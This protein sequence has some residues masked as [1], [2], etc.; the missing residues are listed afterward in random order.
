MLK[1]IDTYCMR[2]CCF[3]TA[4][5]C[6]IYGDLQTTGMED[7]KDKKLSIHATSKYES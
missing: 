6:V 3:V 7:K 2:F 1:R 4:P 5:S